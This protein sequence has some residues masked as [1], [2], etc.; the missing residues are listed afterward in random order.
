[1]TSCGIQA[2]HKTNIPSFG[3]IPVFLT[4]GELN[5]N[6]VRNGEPKY[7]IREAFEILYKNDNVDLTNKIPFT[8]PTDIYMKNYFNDYDYIVTLKEYIKNN[9]FTSQQ[10]WMVYCLNRFIKNVLNYQ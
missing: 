2:G 1:M 8:R 5:L 7:I 3:S 6:R 9:N 4:N 10:K